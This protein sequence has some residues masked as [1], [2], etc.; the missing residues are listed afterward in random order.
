M[1]P[2]LASVSCDIGFHRCIVSVMETIPTPRRR[3]HITGRR[4]GGYA[5]RPPDFCERFH[6]GLLLRWDPA[7]ICCWSFENRIVLLH[8]FG[9]QFASR[10]SLSRLK[11]LSMTGTDFK[12]PAFVL[13]FCGC[14]FPRGHTP[15]THGAC[16]A[17]WRS[18]MRR[19]Q[20]GGA[21]AN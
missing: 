9:K 17:P 16:C 12:R 20:G 19:I 14:E 4:H 10:E 6:G 1:H 5:R 2:T 15:Y 11:E 3:R 18:Q 8:T 7:A 21:P 13:E